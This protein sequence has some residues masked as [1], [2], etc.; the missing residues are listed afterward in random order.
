MANEI[1]SILIS[2]ALLGSNPIQV[3]ANTN[4][5]QPEPAQQHQ[6]RPSASSTQAFRSRSG[7]RSA[8][9]CR[10]PTSFTPT[11]LIPNRH[12]AHLIDKCIPGYD[13]IRLSKQGIHSRYG[14]IQYRP[15]IPDKSDADV[16]RRRSSRSRVGNKFERHETRNRV[17]PGVLALGS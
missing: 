17:N 5:L 14:S 11:L 16:I 15:I 2:I 6:N 10:V 9:S 12:L 4:L 8:Y 13:L 3:L 1:S 7:N